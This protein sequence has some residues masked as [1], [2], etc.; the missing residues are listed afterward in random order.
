MYEPADAQN[1]W[2]LWYG[3][4]GLPNDCKDQ[5]VMYANSTDGLRWR[6]PD[7]GIYSATQHFPAI[8]KAEAK[9]NNIVMYGGGLG[10]LREGSGR[11]E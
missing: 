2:Q 1:P 3:G 8:P 4:C 11:G 9:Q 10:V 6:K 7:L 5:F